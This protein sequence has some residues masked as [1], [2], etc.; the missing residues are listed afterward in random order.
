VF[1]IG[2]GFGTAI[3]VVVP[4][5]ARTGVVTIVGTTDTSTLQI[6]PTVVDIH[7]DSS[8]FV[9]GSSF[10]V[11]GS[12]F[13][14]G[15]VIIKFGA[16]EVIDT[17]VSAGPDVYNPSLSGGFDRNDDDGIVLSVPASASA[18]PIT[19][20]TNGGTSAAFPMS[21]TQLV[22]TALAGT[23]TSSGLPSANPGQTI[24]ILGGGLDLTTEVIFPIIDINGN[25]ANRSVRPSFAKVDRTL[26]EVTV[27]QD[28]VTGNVLIIGAAGAFPLQIVPTLEFVSRTGSGSQVRLLGSGFTENSGLS[29]R[30]GF[31]SSTVADTGANIDVSSWFLSNDSIVVTPLAGAGEP[32]SVST[33]GGTSTPVT[34]S[35]DDPPAVGDIRDIAVFPPTAGADAGRLLV[36]EA[37]GNLR[38]LDPVSLALVRTITRPGAAAS[39]IGLDFLPE[40]ITVQDP[41]RG[42][43]AVPAGSIIIVNGNDNPDRLYYMNP[44]GAGTVLAD[45]PLGGPNLLDTRDAAGVAFHPTRHTLFVLRSSVIVLE[46]DPATGLALKSFHMPFNIG[47]GGIEVGADGSLWAGGSGHTAV[48]ALDPESGRLRFGDYDPISKTH[49]A[50]VYFHWY[51]V[52]FQG[53]GEISGVTY[54]NAGNLL[55]STFGG[56]VLRPVLPGAP[57]AILGTDGA[58]AVAH[59]GSPADPGLPSANA[60]QTIRITGSGFSRYTTVLFPRVVEFGEPGVIEITASIVNADGSE[61]EL[62]VPDE[63][64]TGFLRI[65]GTD[66]PG[67]FLQVVPTVRNV[68]PADPGD[69]FDYAVP[70]TRIGLFGSGFVEGDTRV[71]FG[72]VPMDDASADTVIDVLDNP[73]FAYFRDNGRLY[74]T[75][76]ERGLTAP[77]RVETDGGSFDVATMP[78]RSQV[79]VGLS[80]IT[81]TSTSGMPAIPALPSANAGQTITLSGFG[82]TGSSLITFR[83]VA[84]DGST[85]TIVAAPAP[86]RSPAPL[87]PWTCR[88]CPP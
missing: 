3:E 54:D 65:V 32:V 68:L 33:A 67:L 78:I 26:I 48:W 11:F 9:T 59:D 15:N 83:A 79:S 36:A 44:A 34:T 5:N 25:V 71:T 76:P 37:F 12:G 38:V 86:S 28:A 22:A 64:R 66:G 45:V 58:M 42:A 20:E 61:I 27:P 47:T 4:D 73:T 75:V 1:D 46:V 2:S 29:V 24:R 19:V 74:L 35:T 18:G 17:Q 16:T 72:A 57:T 50:R 55:V 31:A 14:E 13:I 23:A 7:L 8:S 84:H 85:G 88:S 43:V 53:T 10:R 81:A 70:G 62:V 52:N 63:A 69:N 49:L 77:V 60:R 51:G 39:L 6:V 56:R 21:V 30:F 80:S 41:V 87:P 82:F 40:A